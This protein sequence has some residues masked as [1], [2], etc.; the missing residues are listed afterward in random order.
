MLFL[1]RDPPCRY[2]APPPRCS[3]LAAGS[4]GLYYPVGRDWTAVARTPWPA[5][6]APLHAASD[7]ADDDDDDDDDEAG[8]DADAPFPQPAWAVGVHEPVTGLAAAG[9]TLAVLH[10]ASFVFFF[11]GASKHRAPVD[12][13]PGTTAAGSSRR[14]AP[15]RWRCPPARWPPR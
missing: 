10:P 15:R 7:D 12:V 14:G 3:V 5:L 1:P 13:G 6:G 4:A 2:A 8:D 11:F 9:D